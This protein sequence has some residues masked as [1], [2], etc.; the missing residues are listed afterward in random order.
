MESMPGNYN[1]LVSL[2]LH[3]EEDQCV[4]FVFLISE[5]ESLDLLF[6][7]HSCKMILL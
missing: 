5:K 7:K 4:M 2:S 6:K 1:N 3:H